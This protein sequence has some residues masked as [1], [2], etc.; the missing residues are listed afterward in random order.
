MRIL[1]GLL[2]ILGVTAAGAAIPLIFKNRMSGF[3]GTAVVCDT[4]ATGTKLGLINAEKR[5]SLLDAV[6]ASKDV[7]VVSA[8]LVE[9]ARNGCDN[10]GG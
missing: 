6:A 2:I 5:K 4:L 9:G 1:L 8:S 7:D 10:K 3:I